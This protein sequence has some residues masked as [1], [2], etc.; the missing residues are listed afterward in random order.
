MG[1]A[2]HD[3]ALDDLLRAPKPH[4]ALGRVY[5]MLLTGGTLNIPKYLDEIRSNH[6]TRSIVEQLRDY[7][8]C[9][10]EYVR[11][12]GHRLIGRWHGGTLIKVERLPE[13]THE[14]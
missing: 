9:E 13:N 4:S 5:A 2:H 10:L 6:K 1:K 12:V 8:S 11:G 14:T 3:V 7:Y